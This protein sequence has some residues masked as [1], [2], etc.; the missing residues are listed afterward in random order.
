VITMRKS[1]TRRRTLAM[2]PCRCGCSTV[3]FAYSEHDGDVAATWAECPG[4]AKTSPSVRGHDEAGALE[5][6]NRESK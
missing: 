4:C 3:T 6:W 5:V 2:K 1:K